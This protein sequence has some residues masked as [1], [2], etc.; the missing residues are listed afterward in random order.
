[1]GT[2][3]KRK[4]PL[5]TS[6]RRTKLLQGIASGMNVSEAGR[7]AGYS[8]AQ[9]AHRSLHRIRLQL[10]DIL[11]K[12]NV[13]VEKV[14][15]KLAAKMEAKETRHFTHQGMVMETRHVAAHAVQLRAAVE[16]AKIMGLYPSA[17]NSVH[18]SEAE[19]KIPGIH[20][21][22]VVGTREE[23][24]KLGVPFLSSTDAHRELDV[25]SESNDDE[26]RRP[27]PMP[28]L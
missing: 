24:Q 10:P 3:R 17:I 1:M 4:L 13:P 27:G 25:G 28:E 23:A 7:V 12:M 16:L 14:I 21:T 8:N 5:Q 20:L 22:I 19:D 9:S 2:K 15:K 26:G 6:R 18:E 11:E